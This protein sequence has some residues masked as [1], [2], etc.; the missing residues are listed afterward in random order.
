MNWYKESETVQR[1]SN[2]GIEVRNG[3]AILYRGTDIPGLT[4]EDLRY[5]DFLSS[6]ASGFDTTG[7]AAADSY[8]PHVERY[9]IPIKD[10]AIAGTGEI[11]YKGHSKSL[12]SG[13]KYPIEIYKAYNDVYG[14]NYTSE[15]IDKMDYDHVKSVARMGL[16]GGLEE[17][18]M[19]VRK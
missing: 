14:S 18:D 12:S 16:S 7:N 4:I 5:G 19:L 8:G 3:K 17:F 10:V 11:Q 9:E 2:Y 6:K 15:E 13:Q 1:L